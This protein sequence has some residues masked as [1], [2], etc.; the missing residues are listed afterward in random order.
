MGAA[1]R[2]VT[3]LACHSAAIRY[4][5]SIR[6]EGIE[7]TTMAASNVAESPTRP[8]W[9]K[10]LDDREYAFVLSYTGHFNATRAAIDAGAPKASAHNWGHIARRRPHVRAAIDAAIKEAMPQIKLTIA[11]RLAAILT[12]DIG[13]VVTWGKKRVQTNFGDVYPA[14]HPKA[15]QL[16][17][18]RYGTILDVDV[19]D[20]KS[21][22]PSARAAVKAI[23]KR[24]G[25]YGSAIDIQLHDPVIAARGLAEILDLTQRDDSASGGGVIFVIEA[26]DG[27][28]IS[29]FSQAPTVI[30]GSVIDAA[31]KANKEPLADELPPGAVLDIETPE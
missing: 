16:K 17:P 21:I 13:D 8:R 14:G 5:C 26:P 3:P 19:R 20:L 2:H 11:E 28:Q 31:I 22:S 29:H 6:V 9:A 4:F 15:G 25:P 12:T 18:P 1:A 24:V 23:R 30:E 10:D 7:R 27:S